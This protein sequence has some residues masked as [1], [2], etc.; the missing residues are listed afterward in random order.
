MMEPM[1]GIWWLVRDAV[2]AVRE[3]PEAVLSID[4]WRDTA[5]GHFDC[6]ERLRHNRPDLATFEYT[7]FT[8]GRVLLHDSDQC[9]VLY[10]GREFLN[11]V[12]LQRRI[13]REFGLERRKTQILHDGHYDKA[14]PLLDGF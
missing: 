3:M 4:G 13:A 12:P 9:F 8:R 5:A 1:I 11:S 7:D 2:V 6:W 10:G 14:T